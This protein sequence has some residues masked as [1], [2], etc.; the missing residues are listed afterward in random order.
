MGVKLTKL[1]RKVMVENRREP[2]GTG[3]GS[4]MV[5]IR[6]YGCLHGLNKSNEA[7]S[8]KYSP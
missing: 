8:S 1:T 2:D 7:D 5:S 4:D 6:P 3:V